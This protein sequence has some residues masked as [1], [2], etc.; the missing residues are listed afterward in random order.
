MKKIF[1][2]TIVTMTACSTNTFKNLS[3]NSLRI[4]DFSKKYKSEVNPVEFQEDILFLRYALER[5][6][7]GK[8]TIDE[9]IFKSV[10]KKLQNLE[11]ISNSKELCQKIGKVLSDFPD[12]HLK[13]KYKGTFCYRPNIKLVD[14]GKN[15]ND[16][17]KPWKGIISS[18]KVYTIAIS[19]FTP[20]KWPGFHDFLDEAVKKAKAIIIDL[21]GN[22][23]GDDSIGYEMAEKLAGQNIETPIAPDVRRRTPETLVIWENYLRV[24]KSNTKNKNMIT[25]LDLY[26]KENSVLMEKSL[27]GELEEFYTKPIETTNWKYDRKKGFLLEFLDFFISKFAYSSKRFTKR[28]CCRPYHLNLNCFFV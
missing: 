2:L 23:G 17:Q 9:S 8:G 26:L 25:Q 28:S 3:Y 10:D 22:G 19:K 11:L 27:K 4:E 12:H 16:T 15:K 13:A 1:L 24:L 21:R 7:G 20:G 18:D 14:V 5:A 6:Y